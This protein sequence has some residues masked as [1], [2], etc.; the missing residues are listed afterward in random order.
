MNTPGSVAAV[1]G[2]GTITYALSASGAPAGFIY[3]LQGNGDLWVLQGATH[4]L[5]VTLDQ[6]GAYTVSQVNPIDH[7]AG[8]LENNADFT[9]TFSATDA[10]GDSDSGTLSIS[11]DD[12]SPD[13]VDDGSKGSFDD[14]SSNVN[15]GTVASLLANDGYGADGPAAANSIT[16]A[17]GSL[18]G[19]ISI[20]GGN[21]MY[22][23]NHNV[24]P[25]GNAVET[26]TYTITDGDGDTDTATFTVTLTD[27]GPTIDAVPASILVDEEGLAGGI[28]GTVYVDGSDLAGVATSQSGT[29][30]GLSFGVDGPG[31]IVLAAVADTGLRTLANQVVASSWNPATHTL[32]GFVDLDANGFDAGDISVFTLQITD[33]ATGAYTYTQ[34]VPVK[35][36]TANTEDNATFNV[37]VT[38]TDAEGDAANGNIS[39]LIDDDSPDAVD[40]GS[41]GTF[42]D[43]ATNFN[44]GNVLGLL[45]ND[46]FGADGA[47]ASNS[48]TIAV[49][50]LGGTISIDGSGNMLY[51]ANHDTIPGNI[52]VET[53]TYT[54]TDADGDTDTATFTVSLTDGGPSIAST[55][56]V[57]DEE[58]LAGGIAG[59]VY[60]DGSDLPGTAI[61]QSGTLIGLDFGDDGVGDIVLAAVAD[62]GLR[63]LA[64]QVVASSWNL[65]THTLTGF[66]DLD[67]NGF[68]AGDISVFTLQI[69]DVGDRR[70]HLHAAP[71]GEA[72]DADTEDNVLF[73]V[74]VTVTDFEGDPAVGSI[75]ILIDDDSPDAV[76]DGSKGSFDDNSSNVNIGTVASLLAN[77]GYGAD[78]PAAANSITI[79]AGS[80]GGTISIVGGN[81]MYTSNHNVAPGGNAVETFT[82]T[83]T[84]GD[85]DT[86]TATFT[87]TLTDTGPTIDAVPASILVDEEGLAGGIA[88]TVYVDG[89]D[90]AGVATSQS[91][92]LSGLS[93]GVDGPGNI[94]LAA[95]ADTGLRTLA[96]QVVASSW[97]PATH[98]LTGF[99]DL[100]ANGFDAGD[101]SVFTLQ[102]TDVATGAYTYTQLVPVKHATAN[103]E[104]NATFNVGVTVTD[105]EGDAANRQHQRPHRRRLADGYG[106]GCRTVPTLQ[107]DESNFGGNAGPT[108][109]AG[110]FSAVLALMARQRRTHSSSTSASMPGPPAW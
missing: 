3:A 38:V 34:L 84:D 91:G 8:N 74:A 17:A 78:G 50:S 64:N 53:F 66:V 23:S 71:A 103:T 108:S 11:V 69:T 29:L 7:A 48:V 101:I 39:V 82:Y 43:G 100:D 45:V 107:V 93:F 86:D 14:N 46:G 72:R 33:V 1:G 62:T 24:A 77:D 95:V 65:A 44:I 25:G 4:V 35:H 67:A 96:N 2:D 13:A 26:F 90:L 89:S 87:V 61:T 54:I 49:G 76:D 47:A 63:T 31:N 88:G 75:N 9:V 18:G 41:R 59:T 81:L 21:L 102:I 56:I 28:A 106:Q 68:D 104:D 19:T 109:F 85:G 60:G 6:S 70:L 105:A 32:T 36:A 55:G 97:N 37:G 20:V 40:D 80:L 10:D 15:I 98:T 52:D 110:L 99:V 51:T 27:T 16:I 73:S 57:I 22:T 79:A 92:T 58:G 12:D 94:V 42:D 83:I 5:T 30:S